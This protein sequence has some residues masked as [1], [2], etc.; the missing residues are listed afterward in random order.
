MAAPVRVLHVVTVLDRGGTETLLMNYYRRMDRSRVQFDFIVH[1]DKR[2]AYEEEIEKLGGR[3]FRMPAIRPRTL[4][5]YLCGLD[6]FFRREAYGVVHAHL[7]ALSSFALKAAKRRGVPVRIAHSHSAGFPDGGVR[8]LFRIVSRSMLGGCC[9]HRFACSAAAGR[10]LF[11]RRAFGSPGSYVLPNAVDTGAFS[12]SEE[13]RAAVRK[14]FGISDE[15][16]VGHV[17]NFSAVKNHSFIIKVFREMRKL[18]GSAKLLLVG[19]GPLLDGAESLARSLGVRDGVIFAG[20]VPNVADYLS[21][22]D[23]FIFPSL[24][25]GFGVAALEAQCSGLPVIASSCL[26]PEAV[27]SEKVKIMENG[28]PAHFWA[29]AL[30]SAER[31]DRLPP[32]GCPDIKEQAAKLQAFYLNGG[33]F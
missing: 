27:F 26:P 9:T 11:G 4:P 23:V 18:D 17:G 19:D 31:G 32:S 16:V 21:A 3:V 14:K 5:A 12:F 7:D 13:A 33:R 2:G 8:R 30:L 20:N 15:T 24:H 28:K 6:G 29:E 1:R 10:F 22:M 25:E